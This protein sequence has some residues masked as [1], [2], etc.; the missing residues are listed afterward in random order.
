MSKR[1]DQEKNLTVHGSFKQNSVKDVPVA[2]EM[3][4]PADE[5]PDAQDCWEV[6]KDED[7]PRGSGESF[8]FLAL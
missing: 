4:L 7:Q 1:S 6:G 2:C 5:Y 8:F 3:D